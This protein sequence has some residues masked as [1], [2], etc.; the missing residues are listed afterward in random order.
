MM[1]GRNWWRANEISM[2]HLTHERDVG[3][4]RHDKKT[5]PSITS[6]G[7][8]AIV[9]PMVLAARDKAGMGAVPVAGLGVCRN[10]DEAALAADDAA[11]AFAF[12]VGEPRGL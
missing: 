6:N 8:P 2:G 12:R 10:F 9:S 4:R 11:F 7:R 3:D 5:S 1:S